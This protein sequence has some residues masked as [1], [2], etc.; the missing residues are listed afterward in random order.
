MSLK[1]NLSDLKSNIIN[2]CAMKQKLLH[3]VLILLLFSIPNLSIAQ[4]KDGD[5]IID[6]LD[7]DDDNDGILDVIEQGNAIVS[8]GPECGGELDFDFS[9]LPT[10]ESGDGNINTLLVGEVFRFSNVGV[11]V[12]ALMTLVSFV[13]ATCDLLDDNSSNV[14]YLKPGVRFASLSGGQEGYVEFNVQFVQSGTSIPVT[15][16][17]V[18]INLNDIDGNTT[19]SEKDKV[20]TPYTYNIDSP[21]DVTV[22]DEGNFLVATSGSVNYPGTSNANSNINLS[23]RY[24][25]LSS[26]TFRLGV[27]ANTNITNVVRYYSLEYSCVTNFINPQ[28]T[29]TD[30]DGDGVSNY[31]DIDSDND[32]IPDNVEAQSTAGYL[33]PSGSVNA[34]GIVTNYPTGINPQDSDGDGLFDHLDNDSDNDGILDIAENGMA[35]AISGVDT[36]NDGLDDVFETNGI[37][38][39]SYDVNE[40]IENPSDLSIL[41]DADGDLSNGGDVDYRDLFDTN[42]PI[43]SNL[44]LDG[45]DDY[46]SC[47]GFLDDL[48]NVT[49]MAW[50]K[51]DPENAAQS[52]STIV[53]EDV[54]C[55]LVAKDGNMLGFTLRTPAGVVT[56][57][58]TFSINYNEWHHVAGS[59]SNSTGTV[60]LYIDGELVSDTNYANQ[61]GEK[62]QNTSDSNGSFEIGRKSSDVANQEYFNGK[63]DEVRVFDIAL[64]KDQIQQMVFQEIENNA[65]LVKGT[66]IN[67]NVEDFTT[68][69][70]VSWSNLLAYYPMTDIKNNITTDYSLN[71]NTLRLNNITTL[72]Q[73][74][75]PMPFETISDDDWSEESTWLHGDVWDIEDATTNKDW[76][77]VHIKNEVSSTNSHTH[78]GLFIDTNK[79]L[80]INGDHKVEN[81]WYLELNGTLDLAGDSQLVQGRYSDL[82]TSAQGKVLRR[83][84]GN[85]SVYWYNYWASPVG[86]LGATSLT[87][88]NTTSNNANN[89]IYRLNLLKKGDASNVQFTTA[90]DQVGR[91]SSRWLY[92]Y[93]NGVTYYDFVS[94]D[95]NTD[96]QPGVGYT[97]KGTGTTD[98]EQQYLFEGKPN[99]GTIAINVTDTGGSG[100][101]PSV[102]KTDYLLGNPYAS[103]IDAHAFIDD[104][105]G[106][107]GGS[108]QLW[109]Q[110]SGT[111]HNLSDYNGGYAVVNKI[112]SVRASQFIGLDGGNSGGEEG[113]KLPTRY[114]PVG[115]GFLTEIVSTGTVVFKNSQRVFVKESDANGTSDTGA[116]FL[117]TDNSGNND[118]SSEEDQLMQKIRL[119]FASVDGPATRRELLLGFSMF[120]SDAFD[121]GYDAKNYNENDDDLN[122]ILDDDLM[123]IQSYSAITEDKI[124]PLSLNTSGQYSYTIKATFFEHIEEDQKV[125]LKDNFTGDYFDLKSGQSY[126]F[127]SE[128]GTFNN[129]FE[130]VFQSGDTLSSQETSIDSNVIYFSNATNSLFVKGLQEDAQQL[131]FTNILG[132]NVLDLGKIS[133]EILN[134]GL[135]IPNLNTG[136]YFVS[137]KTKKHIKIKKIIIE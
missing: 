126:E 71:S 4:D 26:Y 25:D 109:Q 49:I 131:V 17:E 132:Q 23:C 115:Q 128:I 48:D 117:R 127:S 40:D 99:N 50:V 78:L 56:A 76:S 53:G 37:N 94:I 33:A 19:L 124:V 108:I 134:N 122:L 47:N 28:V 92:T 22:T 114:V 104:N 83:Q 102:S 88:N 72:Q 29:Y 45:V 68:T 96:I 105:V 133:S 107:I 36:D 75:A 113:T 135:E 87:D 18:F 74:T 54:S 69:N 89:S 3:T 20:Q 59:F 86:A 11:G 1:K 123:I 52:L 30:A 64:S 85:S 51:I 34:S 38:D 21:T 129:R 100:S 44:D 101:V 65:G 9:A 16:P 10:E 2:R 130:I 5:S 35:N 13:N 84:E 103:A 55:R 90:H 98:P 118:S 73:Q 43:E 27:I 120:T 7:D 110:W 60:A 137:L 106:V 91:V 116:V 41:P 32:G 58:P 119:E 82:V 97:Q 14:T 67:K 12:D 42:P 61:I 62:T 121:Y 81:S 39:P 57:Y 15:V 63:V 80:T 79:K 93:K 46:L 6:I 125:Y 111:S 66:V 24:F 31:L 8:N 70:T 77:I 136:I 112:G 95:E